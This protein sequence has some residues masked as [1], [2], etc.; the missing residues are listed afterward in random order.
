MHRSGRPTAT[1]RRVA[2]AAMAGLA[3]TAALAGAS[4]SAGRIPPYI[5][6]AVASPERTE[7]MRARDGGRKPAEI[8]AMSGI[9]P[10]DRVIEIAS[11]G[12]YD[13]TMLAK[14][15]GPKGRVFM[16]DLP[17]MKARAEAPTQ[18][19]V[20]AHPNTKY[21]IG[22]FDKLTF[23]QKVD[24]VVI[25]M[26]Y[27]DLSINGIDVAAFNAKMFEALRPGGRLLIV[28]HRA[29]PGSGRRD[30]KT[31]HRIDKP[32]ILQEVQAA[33][34]KLVTDS[35]IFANPKD[36]YDVKVTD[37][38]ERGGTDRAVLVFQKPR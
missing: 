6:A 34:L 3:L 14:I 26:Y 10:G 35:D 29:E 11:F 15:V 23:P 20:A 2:L 28:D 7:A 17:Y 18:A 8:F 5:A 37:P 19:F 22:D 30:S 1:A 12:Q 31:L 24:L 36:R 25:D 21:A 27:H 32:L 9:R 4:H 33:G 38:T 16:Y 13:T